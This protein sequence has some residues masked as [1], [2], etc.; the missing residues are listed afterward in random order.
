M[1][2]LGTYPAAQRT[3]L[4]G[5][6]QW[7]DYTSSDPLAAITG[8]LDSMVTHDISS[9]IPLCVGPVDV[10]RGSNLVYRVSA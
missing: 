7:S 2:A 4:S 6:S 3:T 8:G 9:S 5:T 1:F 10:R